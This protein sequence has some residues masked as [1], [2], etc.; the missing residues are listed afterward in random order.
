MSF[1]QR[2][3]DRGSTGPLVVTAAGGLLAVC[4]VVVT[5]SPDGFRDGRIALAFAAFI[6]PQI[7][8]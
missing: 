2:L 4:A 7:C 3:S 6:A 8:S 1:G 5:A